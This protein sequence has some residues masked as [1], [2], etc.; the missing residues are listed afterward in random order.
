MDR[1]PR[2]LVEQSMSVESQKQDAKAVGARKRTPLDV[3]RPY[4]EHDGTL[5]G[6]LES[7]MRVD[8]ERPFLLFRGRHWKRREFHAA[9]IA[10]ARSLRQRGIRAGD[11][12]GVL[13]RNHEGHV[14]LL[15]AA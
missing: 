12:I 9:V 7:R 10:L 14:L 4:P 6:A 8:A 1:T 11:R 5:M 13:A 15:F 2:S 3:L